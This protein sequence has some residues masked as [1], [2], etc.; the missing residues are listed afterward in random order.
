MQKQIKGGGQ[1]LHHT[2]TK[3]ITRFNTKVQVQPNSPEAESSVL[4]CILLDNDLMSVCLSENLMPSEFFD[5]RNSAIYSAMLSLYQENIAIDFVTLNQKIKEI[6]ASETVSVL[7]LSNIAEYLPVAANIK[8]FIQIV[9]S[10]AKRRKYISIAKQIELVSSEETDIEKIE[11][12]IELLFLENSSEQNYQQLKDVLS[13]VIETKE[14]F[15]HGIKVQQRAVWGI[16]GATSAGKTELALDLSYSFASLENSRTVL[17]CEYEGTKEDLIIRVQRKAEHVEGWSDKPIYISVKPSFLEITDFVRKHKNEDILIV[18][19]YLQRFARKLQGEDER[20]SDNLRLYVNS[21]YN[22][23]DTLRQKNTNVS[24]CFL[25]SMSK[26]GISEVSRQKRAE[27]TD[28]LNSIKESGD[29]QYDLDYAYAMLF[30]ND[31]ES[32]T[33]S[34][35]RFSTDGKP[36][37]YMHIYPIKEARIGEPLSEEIYGFSAE[38]HV[39]ERVGMV[40]NMDNQYSKESESVKGGFYGPNRPQEPPF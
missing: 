8:Y 20:P 6:D 9:K 29:V 16:V 26:S 21:I 33:L 24:V 5:S 18:V 34:L 37:K 11:N 12:V 27:K 10:T 35:S 7:Y 15:A 28:M 13:Q 2:H 36:K 32:D 4:C 3:N 39:Y 30:S 14:T 19:D 22:F 38:R 40:D 17:F 31:E 25:M 23:F 1:S